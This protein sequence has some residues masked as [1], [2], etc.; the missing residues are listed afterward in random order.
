MRVTVIHGG[1]NSEHEISLQSGR[2]VI[3]GL[4]DAGIDARAMVIG[5][6]GVWSY[7]GTRLGPTPNLSIA[8]AL[9]LTADHVWFPVLHGRLGEDGTLAALAQLRGGRWVGSGVNAGAIA[10]NKEACKRLAASLG[11]GTAAGT[12][13]TQ[14][15]PVPEWTA[16]VVVKPMSAGSSFGVSLVRGESE[17]LPA[18]DR[19]LSFDSSILIEEV[20]IGREIDIAVLR[21]SDGTLLV[22]PPLEICG[23]GIFDTESK[24]ESTPDFRFPKDLGAGQTE[25]LERAALDLYRELDCDSVARF[26]FFLTDS[27]RLVL[28]EVNTIPG[29]TEHSQVPLMF[30]E[31]GWS[32]PKLLSELVSAATTAKPELLAMHLNVAQ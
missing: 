26:D 2:S 20:I 6:D 32:Y 30:S 9:E 23:G 17:Y 10:M 22:G 13:L 29:M 4:Q 18:I 14:N 1:Q 15:R 11:I 5:T 19:A 7:Q 16:P 3:K 21:R 24:Y 31:V 27:G 12:V 28:N 8:R 25:A